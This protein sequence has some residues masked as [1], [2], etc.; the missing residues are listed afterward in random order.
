MAQSQRQERMPNRVSRRDE[1]EGVSRKGGD[2]RDQDE[3]RDE[4][5]EEEYLDEEQVEEEDEP[6]A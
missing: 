1:G 4:Y 6:G 3:L 5:G 2:P